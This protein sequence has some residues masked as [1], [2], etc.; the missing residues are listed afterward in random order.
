MAKDDAHSALRQSAQDLLFCKDAVH[1]GGGG[2]GGGVGDG[3]EGDE[4]D[5]EVEDDGLEARS[6]RGPRLHRAGEKWSVAHL[7]VS[8]IW[9]MWR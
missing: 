6:A 4:E 7:L 3:E 1:I 2:L 9:W 8:R 5:D